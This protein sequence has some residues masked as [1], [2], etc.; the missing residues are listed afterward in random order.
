MNKIL[1]QVT[2]LSKRKHGSRPTFYLS[3][4]LGTRY[5]SSVTYFLVSDI[6]QAYKFPVYLAAS[7][8]LQQFLTG[9]TAFIYTDFEFKEVKETRQDICVLTTEVLG[10]FEAGI[11]TDVIGV[12]STPEKAKDFAKKHPLMLDGRN[13]QPKYRFL[14]FQ[15][16]KV[17]F[18]TKIKV[19]P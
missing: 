13:N 7:D 8:G 17:F 14:S 6:S 11:D 2:T 1:V 15:M 10:D 9:R 16:D 5:L 3:R 4:V 18:M 19:N 12:F